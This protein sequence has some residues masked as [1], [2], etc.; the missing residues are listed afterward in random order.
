MGLEEKEFHNRDLHV[1]VLR[2]II[3]SLPSYITTGSFNTE[4]DGSV[5]YSGR[6]ISKLHGFD[7]DTLDI[8]SVRD[9]H[10]HIG[11]DSVTN[12]WWL[13]PD[14][15]MKSGLR[16]I[17][18]DKEL[19]EMCFHA[20]TNKGVVHVYYEHKSRNWFLMKKKNQCLKERI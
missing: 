9:C 4:S 14:R 13:V 1:A 20:Q 8:F 11:S 15:P 3:L 16:A 10:K 19:M 5:S 18:H 2:W 12:C 6:Q 17:T 7:V